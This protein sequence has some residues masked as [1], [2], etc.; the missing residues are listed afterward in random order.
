MTSASN[1][2]DLDDLLPSNFK[3]HFNSRNLFDFRGLKGHQFWAEK[4]CFSPESNLLASCSGD[5][6]VR[7]WRVADDNLVADGTLLHFATVWCCDFSPDGTRLCSCCSEGGLYV[8]N[9]ATKMCERTFHRKNGSLFSCK[10]SPDGDFVAA[11][12]VESVIKLWNPAWETCRVLRGHKNVVDD[13]A[14][15]P[16][17]NIIASVS[18]DRTCRLWFIRGRYLKTKILRGHRHWVTSCNFS[19]GGGLLATTSMDRTVRVWDVARSKVVHVLFG[20]TCIVWS[21]AFLEVSGIEV[22]LSCASDRS[23]RFWRLDEG[24]QIHCEREIGAETLKD[25]RGNQLLSCAASHNSKYVALSDYEGRLFL[26]NV[27]ET[28]ANLLAGDE[29]PNFTREKRENGINVERSKT[30]KYPGLL[31]GRTV[32]KHRR[33]PEHEHGAK[34]RDD[35]SSASTHDTLDLT[36]GHE[37]KETAV[38]HDSDDLEVVSVSS[39]DDLEADGNDDKDVE[40]VDGIQDITTENCDKTSDSVYALEQSLSSIKTYIRKSYVNVICYP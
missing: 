29:G 23:L 39:D 25:N 32:V 12:G 20:H 17:G 26:G 38:A 5:M 8:W 15:S 11:A 9:V 6:S 16:C 27:S 31:E 1:E 30:A 37:E 21:C 34:A 19:R 22:L 28:L 13:I 36:T 10:F 33:G 18:K 14:F 24:K 35:G 2:E 3:S 4:C 40:R 7:I